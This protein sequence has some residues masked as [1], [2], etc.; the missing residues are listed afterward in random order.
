MLDL[1]FY[2]KNIT[3]FILFLKK[4]SLKYANINILEIKKLIVYF[5]LK[6]IIDLNNLSISNYYYFFKYF[7]G[8]IPFFSSYKYSFKLNISYYNFII[9]YNFKKKDIYYIFFFFINDIYLPIS[10]NSVNIKKEKNYWEF[11][12]C[13]MNFFVEKKNSIGF[14][15]L[16]DYINFKYLFNT[17]NGFDYVNY[18]SI[19]K[20]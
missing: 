12:I 10:K 7:F 9:L 1:F 6:N 14:F 16:K 2:Y 13:D 19:Y 3:R 20:I 17:N 15:H 5:N 8:K 18:F 11:T 4:S